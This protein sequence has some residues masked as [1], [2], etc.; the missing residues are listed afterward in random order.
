MAAGAKSHRCVSEPKV[1]S[2]LLHLETT[3]LVLGLARGTGKHNQAFTTQSRPSG[4]LFL[5]LVFTFLSS[6]RHKL[7]M[8]KLPLTMF[9][10]W[11]VQWHSLSAGA[12]GHSC[13]T[14]NHDDS[15]NK[16]AS[17][18]VPTGHPLPVSAPQSSDHCISLQAPGQCQRPF[19]NKPASSFRA[20][21]KPPNFAFQV[22]V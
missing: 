9:M 5:L 6:I 13:N 15:N 16:T 10:Q 14:N 3:S 19:F 18:A 7:F 4:P 11:L 12:S 8:A 22:F 2:V 21:E 17:Y 20:R 1:S